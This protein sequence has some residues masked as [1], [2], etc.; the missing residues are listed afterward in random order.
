MPTTI[1]A[2]R[3]YTAFIEGFLADREVGRAAYLLLTNPAY[4]GQPARKLDQMQRSV[5]VDYREARAKGDQ[6]LA[7]KLL[8]RVNEIGEA[9]AIVESYEYI[10]AVP[11]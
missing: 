3:E 2:V 4:Y 1:A 11:R 9:L 8:V 5:I 7:A 10:E 6:E